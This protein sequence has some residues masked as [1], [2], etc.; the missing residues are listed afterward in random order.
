MKIKTR[1]ISALITASLA[2]SLSG[3]GAS[4][5]EV[6][7]DAKASLEAMESYK[8]NSKT[9]IEF[10]S[11]DLTTTTESDYTFETVKSPFYEK[12]E[13]SDIYDG[14][15][16]LSTMYIQEAGDEYELYMVYEDTWIKQSV[17]SDY[18]EYITDFYNFPKS[19][20]NII[21]NADTFTLS[22][23]ENIDGTK[24]LKGIFTYNEENLKQGVFKWWLS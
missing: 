2:F 17:D 20:A 13:M 24:C 4:P 7:A 22:G 11:D 16:T 8:M 15:E 10:S 6:K 21:E 1:I 18:L 3:C 14:E 23:S 9:N 19:V 5:E 12:I